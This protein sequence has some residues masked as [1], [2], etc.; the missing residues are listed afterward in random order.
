MDNI[1]ESFARHSFL[2]FRF[3]IF[4]LLL[5]QARLVQRFLWNLIFGIPF[6][7]FVSGPLPPSIVVSTIVEQHSRN[8]IKWFDRILLIKN[9]AKVSNL[10]T[11]RFRFVVFVPIFT[12]HSTLMD[13]MIHHVVALVFGNRRKSL[14]WEIRMYSH[15][16]QPKRFMNKSKKPIFVHILF[17]LVVSFHVQ[18][19][20]SM[21]Y[22]A[23]WQKQLEESFPFE[24]FPLDFTFQNHFFLV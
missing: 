15:W 4:A 18:R 7:Y 21:H 6:V 23:F 9:S 14:C 10:S 2:C 8:C 16:S 19:N 24:H 5:L 20:S 22:K 17:S 1:I 12:L 3:S 11:F 13:I